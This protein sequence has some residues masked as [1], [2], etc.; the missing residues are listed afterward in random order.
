[1]KSKYLNTIITFLFLTVCSVTCFSQSEFEPS[2]V[3]EKFLEANNLYNDSKYEQSI[4]VYLQILDSGVHSP[5]L[6]FNIGNAYYRINDIANCILNYEKSLKLDSS[7]NEVI[8]NLNMV[9]NALIDDIAVVPP[10]FIDK[11][12]NKISNLLD[13]SSWGTALILLS[14]IF[15]LFFLI[16]FFSNKPIIKRTAFTSLFF[17]I[18]LISLTAWISIN[19]Y[20]KNHLEKYAIIFSTKIEIKADP[21]ERSENLLTLHLGTKVRIIDNFNDVWVKIKLVNGQ[22]GWIKN[23]QIKMI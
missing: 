14:F 1:M 12:L 3:N 18:I 11:Q 10:S 17:I 5:E 7:G 15:L 9:K 22:E 8:N 16:Y 13:Y 2:D 6:Y 19:T 23:D 4:Q 21:N 20:E